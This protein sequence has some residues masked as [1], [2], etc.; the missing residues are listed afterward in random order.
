MAAPIAS[1]TNPASR[2]GRVAHALVAELFHQ[3]FGH[4]ED[5]AVQANIFPHQKHALVRAH[6]FAQSFIQRLY[7]YGHPWQGHID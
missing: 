5:A 4:A 3:V 6:L 1:P 7:A 2:D